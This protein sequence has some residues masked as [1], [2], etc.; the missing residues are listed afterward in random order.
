M[1]IV[2][3]IGSFKVGG[4]ERMSINI[5]EE[6]SRRGH[7]VNYIVQRPIFEISNS[8]PEDK[9]HVLRKKDNQNLT[10]K[11]SA[12]FFGVYRE[13][14]KIKPDVVIA[15]SRVSSFLACFTF[16]KKIIARFDIDPYIL[17]KKQRIWANFVLNFPNVEKVVLQSQGLLQKYERTRKKHMKKFVVIPNPIKTNDVIQN[18]KKEGVIIEK[19]Y[20]TAMGRLSHQ[21]N[22]QLLIEAYSSSEIIQKYKLVIIGDGILKNKL[23]NLVKAKDLS[24]NIIFTGQ[25]ENPYP[26]ISNALFFV[27]TSFREG[28]CNVV[29]EALTL[30]KPVIATDC[31]YGPADMVNDGENGFLIP[32]QNEEELISKLNLLGERPDLIEKFSLNAKKSVE[33]FNIENIGDQWED[34]FKEIGLDK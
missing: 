29:L 23:K 14:A 32:D 5:G 27:N 25:I 34:V 17:S 22:F 15:F 1:K 9:I 6:L 2:I 13:S 8:I 10:Y 20:I 18:S 24:E 31:D 21:K 7:D 26:I 12:L 4:A 30:S 28:F 33:K 3:I 11:V 19:P 16:N